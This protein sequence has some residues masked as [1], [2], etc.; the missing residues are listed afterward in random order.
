MALFLLSGTAVKPKNGDAFSDEARLTSH[1]KEGGLA[2]LFLCQAISPALQ[3][4]ESRT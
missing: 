4:R 3:A 2:P 1:K